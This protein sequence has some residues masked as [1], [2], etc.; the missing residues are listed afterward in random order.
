MK[1]YL[2]LL[3]VSASLTGWLIG[4]QSEKPSSETPPIEQTNTLQEST[5]NHPAQAVTQEKQLY[6]CGMHP[7]IVQD[8]PGYCPICG[9]ELVPL[10]NTSDAEGIITIDPDIVQLIGV[11]TAIVEVRP[12]SRTIRAS[13]YFE[14]PE[15]DQYTITPKIGGWIERLY[16]DAE[17]DRVRSGSPVLEIY[18]PELVTAQEEYL[19]AIRQLEEAR[20]Q[21]N[22]LLIRDAERLVT[23]AKQ[24]LAYW[25]LTETQIAQLAQAG[26]PQKTLPILA[27]ASGIVLKKYV[28]E[29]QEIRPGQPVL[30]LADLRALWIDVHLYEQDLPWIQAGNPVRLEVPYFPGET[31]NG[32]IEFIYDELDARTRTVRARL[33]VPNPDLRLK[34]GMYAIAY[35]QGTPLPPSPVVPEDALILTGERQLVILDLGGGKFK[36]QEVRLGVFADGY[37]QVLEGL[38]GGERI[39]T[40]AQFLIDSE[41]RLKSALGMMGGHQHG[42]MAPSESNTETHNT[43]ARNTKTLTK[44]STGTPI[45]IYP[46]DANQDGMLYQCLDHPTLLQDTPISAAECPDGAARVSISSALELL[47]RSGIP[48]AVDV[49]KADQNG[50]GMLYQCPMHWAVLSDELGNC[51]ICHMNLEHVS[52]EEAIANLTREGYTVLTP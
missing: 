13:G 30:D 38:Q 24:R 43:E 19:L 47:N 50:D 3:A 33:S 2:F 46:I 12:L 34:A 22:S 8:E 45:I 10:K 52:V 20:A 36:P 26:K 27:P 37:A 23:A 6:T 51:E 9:M 48:A 11:R 1:H 49:R 44:N 39:V 32:R 5:H 35:V 21:N 4:C 29:G 31:F 7:N 25:D 41:S 14:I 15:P 17:G 28:V 40:S 42:S 16:I 18:S